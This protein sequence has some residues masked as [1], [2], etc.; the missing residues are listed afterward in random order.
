MAH[1]IFGKD[2]TVPFGNTNTFAIK[3]RQTAVDMMSE[4][5]ASTK[6]QSGYSLSPERDNR[7]EISA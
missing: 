3:E 7:E 5:S 1:Y 6:R 4:W 2:R